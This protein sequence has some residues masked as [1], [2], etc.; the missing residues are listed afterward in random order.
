MS[1]A[2]CNAAQ[3]PGALYIKVRSYC[4]SRKCYCVV[5]V[6]NPRQPTLSSNPA[7]HS[8]SLNVSTWWYSVPLKSLLWCAQAANTT[9]APHKELQSPGPL[10]TKVRSYRH[11]RMYKPG[12]RCE[13]SCTPC[14]SL[15]KYILALPLI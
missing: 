8:A 7:I 14:S 12:A 15:V 4:H 3:S 6:A 9:D 1:N 2:P 11:S 5:V 13:S 10:T